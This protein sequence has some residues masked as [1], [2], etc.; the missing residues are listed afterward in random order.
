MVD[1]L[2]GVYKAFIY[3]SAI[4]FLIALNTS[5]N[6][7]IHATISGYATVAIALLLIMS[8][9][10]NGFN[11]INKGTSTLQM[12][13]N[14]IITIG[15]F[16][17]VL[18]II[19]FLMYLLI[20]Y[21]NNISEGHVSSYYGSFQFLSSVLILVQMYLL[22]DGL[23]SEKFKTM[24]QLSKITSSIICLTAVLNLI[25]AIILYITLKYYA[26]DG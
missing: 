6:T 20:A 8:L 4:L 18:A 16:L 14:V 21:K 24:G 23:D 15:P 13:F 19:G 1:W 22:Y 10:L 3:V 7:T 17:L 25:C 26:T 11:K 5:G 12:I 9:I 2:T